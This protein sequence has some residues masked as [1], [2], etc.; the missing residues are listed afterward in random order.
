MADFSLKQSITPASFFA[1][2]YRYSVPTDKWNIG[3]MACDYVFL[4]QQVIDFHIPGTLGIVYHY[5]TW[6]SQRHKERTYPF[7]NAS[8]FHKQTIYLTQ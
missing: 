5:E 1:L 3:D 4:G 2:G 8:Q 7:L 6:L